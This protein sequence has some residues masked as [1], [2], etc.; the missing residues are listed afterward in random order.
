MRAEFA[1]FQTKVRSTVTRALWRAALSCFLFLLCS[2]AQAHH[3]AEGWYA[4]GTSLAGP[5]DTEA[6]ACNAGSGMF[7]GMQA[8]QNPPPQNVLT[9]FATVTNQVCYWNTVSAG[10][11]PYG[12]VAYHA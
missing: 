12:T 2:V 11:G 9:T 8:A 5:A 6:G 3:G 4:H 10:V 1:L 7:H